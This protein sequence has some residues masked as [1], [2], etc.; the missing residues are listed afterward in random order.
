M[1]ERRGAEREYLCNICGKVFG[2]IFPLQA[3]QRNVHQV[4]G[5]KRKRTDSTTRPKRAR[6]SEGMLSY[7]I[8]LYHIYEFITGLHYMRIG[9]LCMLCMSR[10]VVHILGVQAREVIRVQRLCCVSSISQWIP[11]T[12]LN[13]AFLPTQTKRFM[14]EI[15][16]HSR[17][18]QLQ[19]NHLILVLLSHYFKVISTKRLLA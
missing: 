18:L 13:H 3:H 10:Y 6:V 14:L 12:S 9:A 16:I 1:H 19:T 2:N 8:L 4:G 5:G 11:N 7:C 17:H 15:L